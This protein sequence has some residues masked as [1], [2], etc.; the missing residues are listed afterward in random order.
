MGKEQIEAL[1]EQYRKAGWEVNKSESGNYS[2]SKPV[3]PGILRQDALGRAVIKDPP[4]E[5]K[6]A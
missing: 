1:A 5:K 2:F 6:S 4:R 3:E